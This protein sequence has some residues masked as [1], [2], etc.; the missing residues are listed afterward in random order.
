MT[1]AILLTMLFCFIFL[2]EKFSKKSLLGLGLLTLGIVLI[3]IFS[4]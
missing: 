4:L 1:V 3:I 2:K